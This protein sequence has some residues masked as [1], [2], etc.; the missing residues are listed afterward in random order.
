MSATTT[1]RGF[2][3]LLTI[4]VIFIF[5]FNR[6]DAIGPTV[7][8]ALAAEQEIAHAMQNNDTTALLRMLSD[9]WAV[10]NTNGGIGEGK[11]IFP[12]GVRTG[13]LV[14]KTFTISEPRVRLY[15]DIALVTTKVSLSGVFAGKDFAVHECQ[16]DVL[17]WKDGAWKSVLTHETKAP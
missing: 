1:A 8:N 14:R 9:D 16:T 5:A 15:G 17:Y 11:D 6:R 7:E 2:G 12:I 3:V 10:I 13:H 4:S